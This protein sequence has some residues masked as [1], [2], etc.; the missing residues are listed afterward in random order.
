MKFG[1]LTEPNERNIFLEKSGKNKAGLEASS[2]RLTFLKKKLA[3]YLQYILVILYLDIKQKETINFQSVGLEIRSI[4]VF[5][6]NGLRLCSSS[7]FVCNVSRKIFLM[8][9]SIN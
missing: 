1:Q 2:R 8:L 6:E 5:F 7:H 3:P 4:L 9:Y